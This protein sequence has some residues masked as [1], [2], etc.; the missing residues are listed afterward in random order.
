MNSVSGVVIT[1]IKL[2]ISLLSINGII[3]SYRAW[4]EYLRKLGG[5]VIKLIKISINT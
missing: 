4:M 5:L 3:L 1:A 2:S